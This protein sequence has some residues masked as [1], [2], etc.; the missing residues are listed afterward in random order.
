ME[1]YLFWELK[2]SQ[3]EEGAISWFL[4]GLRTEGGAIEELCKAKSLPTQHPWG[5]EEGSEVVL[6]VK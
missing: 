6:N 3:R 5:M 1:L 4:A 2:V